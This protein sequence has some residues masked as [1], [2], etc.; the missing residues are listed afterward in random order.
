MMARQKWHWIYVNNNA[1]DQ[2][3][4]TWF[5]IEL[6]TFTLNHS[7]LF[8]IKTEDEGVSPGSVNVIVNGTLLWQPSVYRERKL[9]CGY[10]ARYRPFFAEVM[11]MN[12]YRLICFHFFMPAFRIRPV[13][14]SFFLVSGEKAQ[15]MPIY[16]FFR[17]M[18]SL[19]TS[20]MFRERLINWPCLWVLSACM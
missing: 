4:E 6:E 8:Q 10:A 17:T 18:C 2:S 11:N 3:I 12:C 9:S 15:T 19:F 20:L 5:W 7:V 14:I 16:R 13:A 1:G